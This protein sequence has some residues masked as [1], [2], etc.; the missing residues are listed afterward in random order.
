MSDTEFRAKVVCD[1]CGWSMKN[2]V[3]PQWYRRPCP[4]CDAPDVINDDDMEV[5]RT[6]Q[7]LKELGLLRE[8]ADE[9]AAQVRVN[10]AAF[11]DRSKTFLSLRL[12]DK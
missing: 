10:T 7:E 2:A 9:K 3:V 5:W 4:E 8:P 1:E 6:F 11:K 12:R